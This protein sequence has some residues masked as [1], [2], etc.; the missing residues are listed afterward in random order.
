MARSW[1]A[2]EERVTKR[3]EGEKRGK[4]QEKGGISKTQRTN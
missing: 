4:L 3:E 1:W 2:R